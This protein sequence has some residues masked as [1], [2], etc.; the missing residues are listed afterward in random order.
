MIYW[1]FSWTLKVYVVLF[2]VDYFD[3]KVFFFENVPKLHIHATFHSV[4]SQ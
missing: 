3:N 2:Y 1:D 4:R